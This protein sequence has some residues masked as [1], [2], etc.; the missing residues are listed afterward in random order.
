MKNKIYSSQNNNLETENFDL[1]KGVF[2]IFQNYKNLFENN[3]VM[4][5][6]INKSHNIQLFPIIHRVHIYEFAYLLNFIC[7]PKINTHGNFAV[8]YRYAPNGKK[9][10]L[11]MCSYQWRSNKAKLCLPISALIL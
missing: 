6:S 5:Q 3:I 8:I 10:E 11:L 1:D 7:N 4:N 9:I 2:S